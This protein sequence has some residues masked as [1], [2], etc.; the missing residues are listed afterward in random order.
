M[1]CPKCN[2]ELEIFVHNDREIYVCPSCLS[3][4]VPHEQSLT[5][6][7]HFC[8]QQLLHQLITVLVD[9]SLF[10]S[11]KMMLTPEKNL[12]C[13][14]CGSRMDVHDFNKKL[15][16]NVNRCGSC[17]SL[18]LNSMQ[19]PLVSIAFLKN[20]P[21][22]LRFKENINGIYQILA[23]RKAKRIRSIDE[24][25]APFAVMAGLVPAIP[26]G[27]NV[28]TK[29]KPVLTYVIISICIV[30]FIMQFINENIL[31]TFGLYPSDV[32]SGQV[33]QLITY[34]FLH[35][36]ILHIL[37][38]MIFLYIFA[39]TI[40]DQLGRLKFLS[41]YFL[42]AVVSGIFYM[43]TTAHKDIP[44]VGASGAISAVIGA[45]LILFPKAKIRFGLFHP[46]TMQK[47]GDTQ[48][49]CIYYILFWIVMNFILGALQS[50]GVEV[51]IAYWGHIGGF[52]CGVIFA[53]VYKNLRRV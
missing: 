28:L 2:R 24:I 48:I 21:D 5:I 39:K 12:T 43:A 32:S 7:K 27:D 16:F 51:S 35:G 13:P 52:I 22:D 41:L 49:S 40:E 18:W 33:Y 36:G 42:G 14:K 15:R 37:G 6:L 20:S 3:A 44:C 11:L 29:T 53:E 47:I 8:T 31:T 4:L 26:L 46:F 17:G 30:V 19:I 38:N 10:D 25:I 9:E 34:A 45:Y 1:N 50:T 23:K